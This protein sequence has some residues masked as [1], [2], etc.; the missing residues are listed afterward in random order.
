VPI[1]KGHGWPSQVAIG[2]DD[3]VV[4]GRASPADELEPHHVTS[5]ARFAVQVNERYGLISSVNLSHLC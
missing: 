2:L 1:G 4:A 5:R 3:A